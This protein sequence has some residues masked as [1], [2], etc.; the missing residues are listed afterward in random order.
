LIGM[1]LERNWV[2]SKILEHFH[3]AGK[4]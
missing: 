1:V 3:Y 4:P 2:L